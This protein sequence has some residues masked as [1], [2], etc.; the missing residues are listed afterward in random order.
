MPNYEV[1]SPV[2]Q[3]GRRHEPGATV[4]LSTEA[5]KPLVDLGRIAPVK[6]KGKPPGKPQA[7]TETST[8]AA[9]G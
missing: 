4:E 7:A 2:R 6:S 5:A 1:T 8:D 9:E 3:G